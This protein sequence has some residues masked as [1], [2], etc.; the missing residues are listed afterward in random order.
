VLFLWFVAVLPSILFR[1]TLPSMLWKLLVSIPAISIAAPGVG[2]ILIVVD[3]FHRRWR[4]AT[5]IVLASAVFAF[6]LL[7]SP[8][9]SDEL[10][11]V[12]VSVLLR[13]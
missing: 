6:A 9:F 2:L 4:A 8:K 11:W 13:G 7:G 12:R 10:R 1:S 3:L 5:S